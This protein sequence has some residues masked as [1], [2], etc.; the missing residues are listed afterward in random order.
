MQRLT[1][2]QI[3]QAFISVMLHYFGLRRAVS[4][5]K[6]TRVIAGVP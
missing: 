6:V 4:E 2:P 5:P 1:I 3:R